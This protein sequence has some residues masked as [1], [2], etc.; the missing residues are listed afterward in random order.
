[1]RRILPVRQGDSLS[2]PSLILAAS[3]ASKWMVMSPALMK[4][5]E[6]KQR[7]KKK[8]QDK[9]AEKKA[10]KKRKRDQDGNDDDDDMKP[11]KKGKSKAQPDDDEE[12]PLVQLTGYIHVMKPIVEI[13]HQSQ[14]RRPI[15]TTW[16]FQ[17][18][19]KMFFR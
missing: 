11:K 12:R 17:V 5:K 9:Q 10:E 13:T 2:Q 7:Q 15:H 3:P 16:S 1:L 8:Q 19:V 4:Q 18:L 14:T 6:Q